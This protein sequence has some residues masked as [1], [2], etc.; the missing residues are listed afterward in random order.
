MKRATTLAASCFAGLLVASLSLSAAAQTSSGA[1]G[2]T[3]TKAGEGKPLIKSPMVANAN[4]R[5]ATD[6]GNSATAKVSPH[7][8]S[9]TVAQ[10][11]HRVG[12]S[13]TGMAHPGSGPSSIGGPAKFTAGINGSTVRSKH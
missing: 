4:P 9:S 12:I 6:S 13:G 3:I 8:A 1:Q 11:V 2:P 5:P 10:P 7:P